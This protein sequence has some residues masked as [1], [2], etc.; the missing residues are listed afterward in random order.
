MTSCE[1]YL[2]YRFIHSFLFSLSLSLTHFPYF[3]LLM[4]YKNHVAKTSYSQYMWIEHPNTQKT[5]QVRS[6][7]ILPLDIYCQNVWFSCWYLSLY[8]NMRIFCGPQIKWTI[9]DWMRC[10]V[11]SFCR[12]YFDFRFSYDSK[13]C[14]E[15]WFSFSF[16]TILAHFTILYNFIRF[17]RLNFKSLS[18]VFLFLLFHLVQSGKCK[19]IRTHTNARALHTVDFNAVRCSFPS[20]RYM[21]LLFTLLCACICSYAGCRHAAMIFICLSL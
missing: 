15:F 1:L 21:L 16:L 5:L 18:V 3:L 7:Y 20:F 14:S 11:V 4:A 2:S 17:C 12:R 10:S 19:H 13:I 8:L 9:W 6:E